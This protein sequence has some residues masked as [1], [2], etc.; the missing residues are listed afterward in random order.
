MGGLMAY[1]AFCKGRDAE[2]A[3]KV[4]AEEAAAKRAAEAAA[5]REAEAKDRKHR[6]VLR[7]RSRM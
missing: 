7:K 2:E 1:H 4:A 5:K 3:A 6:S